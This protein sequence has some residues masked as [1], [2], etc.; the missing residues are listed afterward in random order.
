[1]GVPRVLG[2]LGRFNGFRRARFRSRRRPKDNAPVKSRQLESTVLI[3]IVI[4]I[5]F[6]LILLV[7]AADHRTAAAGI[8]LQTLAGLFAAVQL[9]ANNASD[10]FVRWAARQIKTNRWH[11]AG[12]LDSRL[13]SLFI[14]TGWAVG[15]FFSLRLPRVLGPPAAIGWPLAIAAVA[16]AVTGAIVLCLALFMFAS[17]VLVADEEPLPDGEALTGLQARLAGNDWVWPFV[18]LA[19]L[20][21][22]ILQVVAA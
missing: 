22:G 8:G 13:R 14:A 15:G 5:T 21:G 20:V 17:A 2:V 12:L 7:R 6:V 4:V 11:V 10:A 9:W 3:G 18:A 19:F 1:M 16:F